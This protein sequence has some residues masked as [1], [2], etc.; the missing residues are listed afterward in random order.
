MCQFR[1]PSRNHC[2]HIL[3][4]LIPALPHSRLLGSSKLSLARAIF[5]PGK[6][7][8]SCA[9]PLPVKVKQGLPFLISLVLNGSPCLS[10]PPPPAQ[11]HHCHVA[12]IRLFRVGCV[13][14]QEGTG[15]VLPAS[16]FTGGCAEDCLCHPLSYPACLLGQCA[17]TFYVV[18]TVPAKAPRGTARETGSV[19][20][21]LRHP[22]SC[23]RSPQPGHTRGSF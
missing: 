12:A 2:S 11:P 5:P 6:L 22:C 17:S 20:P 13:G 18:H 21:S 16:G 15:W 4:S 19:V 9:S 23:C 7:C 10:P 8:L 3:P 14:G 1:A